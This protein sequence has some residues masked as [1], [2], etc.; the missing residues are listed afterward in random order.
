MKA[1]TRIA[2]PFDQLSLD[3]A[4]HVLVVA[5]D[6]G[7]IALPLVK[8]RPKPGHDRAR[9]LVAQ[10]GRGTQSL[11][12]RDTPGDVVFEEHAVEAK[13]NPKT[14]RRRIGRVLESAGPECHEWETTAPLALD[15]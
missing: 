7:R 11:R 12:P 9:V 10:D 15:A 3:K 5:G 6:V 14:E 1:A 8:D 2:N 4:V 13:R